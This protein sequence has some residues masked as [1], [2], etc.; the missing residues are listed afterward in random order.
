MQR[1]VS[2]LRELWRWRA[3]HLLL[4]R[5]RRTIAEALAATADVALS[6]THRAVIRSLRVT[7][8]PVESGAPGLRQN[9]PFGSRRPTRK[10]GLAALGTSDEAL[11]A[12]TLVEA[13]RIIPGL[14]S[15]GS[16]LPPGRYAVPA[17]MR[18]Y[19]AY[20][21]T[22]VL[23]DGT[24]DFRDEHAVLLRHLRWRTDSLAPP[25][26]PMPWVDG[27][28]PYGDCSHFQVDM[29][30][31]LRKRWQVGGDGEVQVDGVCDAE[32][33]TLHRQMLAALQVFLVHATL[34]A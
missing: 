31:H 9:F 7:W 4:A 14:V 5:Q 22:G 21:E 13:G 23:P 10:T 19:F 3:E 26:W 16:T 8:V 32:L 11:L 12:K 15:D 20:P 2:R 25:C 28:R 24:F 17:D 18:N 1:I 30:S 33:E 34:P 29:A 6:P 27:K